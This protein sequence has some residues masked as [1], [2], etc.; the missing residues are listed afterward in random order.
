MDAG[1]NPIV[2]VVPEGWIDRARELTGA[3]GEPT[4]VIGGD[5]RQA[6][7]ANGL[8]A[9]VSKRVIVQDAAR[10]FVTA[11]LIARVLAALGDADA[12]IAAVA[13]SDTLKRVERGPGDALTVLETVDRVSLWRA[14]TPGAFDTEALRAA[15]AKADAEGFVGTDE[16]Q[17][18]ERY[19]GRI[20]I[21]PGS[22]DNI[23]LTYS[24]DFALAE[25]IVKARS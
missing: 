24:E 21:V 4:F 19:G 5:S 18:I 7:V 9:V 12:A 1:C 3:I 23:K 14:Q 8:E 13:L 2:I 17:L 11:D 15:H 20:A 16:S 10:P 25:A 6:S 22:V